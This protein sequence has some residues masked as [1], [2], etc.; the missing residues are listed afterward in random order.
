MVHALQ[1]RRLMPSNTPENEEVDLH[2]EGA[3][4]RHSRDR[5]THLNPYMKFRVDIEEV[6]DRNNSHAAPPRVQPDFTE[7]PV[8]TRTSSLSHGRFTLC[9]TPD[10]TESDFIAIPTGRR[11]NHALRTTTPGLQSRVAALLLAMS[12]IVAEQDRGEGTETEPNSDSG[13]GSELPPAYTE[14]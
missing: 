14:R 12:R 4:D 13:V 6:A 8:P 9:N 5:V 2:P 11:V 1:I 7:D 10:G 3:N